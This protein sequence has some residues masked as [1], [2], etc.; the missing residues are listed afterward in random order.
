MATIKQY[1]ST[2]WGAEKTIAQQMGLDIRRSS[3]EVRVAV[4]TVNCVLA[5]V[6][7]VLTNGGVITDAALQT[8]LNAIANSTIPP[9][10]Y[11][12]PPPDEATGSVPDPDL[13]V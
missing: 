8:Q 7:K 4:L 6:I 10:P 9:Q 3:F 13:G 12:L 11:T 5:A 2:M 1:V